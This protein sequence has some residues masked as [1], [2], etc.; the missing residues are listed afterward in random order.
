MNEAVAL[1]NEKDK[2][3]KELTANI[4]NL[5]IAGLSIITELDSDLYFNVAAKILETNLGITIGHNTLMRL[6]RVHGY[7][8]LGTRSIY[9]KNMPSSKYVHLFRVILHRNTTSGAMGH[10]T[11][12]RPEGLEHI[13]PLVSRWVYDDINLKRSQEGLVALPP[14]PDLWK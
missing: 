10:A 2:Q 14:T 9:E 4:D 7:L 8:L 6:L 13:A 1:A 12:I 11:V 5:R 3:V